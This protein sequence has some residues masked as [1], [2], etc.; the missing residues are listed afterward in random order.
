MAYFIDLFSP[1]TYEAFAHSSRDISGFRLR[2]FVIGAD[3]RAVCS[4]YLAGPRTAF[5]DC[6]SI[7]RS[8]ECP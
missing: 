3:L 8:A 2:H 4:C 7:I 6:S 1:E 5:I